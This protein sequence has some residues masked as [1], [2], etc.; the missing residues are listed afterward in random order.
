M[1]KT[2]IAENKKTINALP[3]ILGLLIGIILSFAGLYLYCHL[4]APQNDLLG[5]WVISLDP[6]RTESDAPT[7]LTFYDDKVEIESA[8]GEKTT[9]KYKVESENNNIHPIVTIMG[10]EGKD[11]KLEYTTQ[12]R[13]YIFIAE[14][15]E[16]TWDAKYDF[17]G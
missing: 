3:F 8:N 10:Y 15:S 2:N 13:L 9:C 6:D 5:G 7:H 17:A 14:G 11:I 4:T 16:E 12:Q 1:D